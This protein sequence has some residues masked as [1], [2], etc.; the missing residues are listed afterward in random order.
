MK[1]WSRTGVRLHVACDARRGDG[2][3]ESNETETT[4]GAD[5]ATV[6]GDTNRRQSSPRG[7]AGGRAG[8]MA[9]IESVTA[10]VTRDA[11]R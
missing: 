7:R 8:A 6:E 5:G 11:T 3:D 1:A 9:R 2:V 4:K 10:L